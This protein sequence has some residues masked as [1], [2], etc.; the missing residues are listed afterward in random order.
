MNKQSPDNTTQATN[1]VNTSP[2]SGQQLGQ[3]TQTQTQSSQL[4]SNE[5]GSPVYSSGSS[6]GVKEGPPLDSNSHLKQAIDSDDYCEI[7]E[8]VGA[9]TAS[10][11][12]NISNR[13]DRPVHA[14]VS[15]RKKPKKEGKKCFFCNDM[16]CHERRFGAFCLREC[17]NYC[18]DSREVNVVSRQG[19]FEIYQRNYTVL[20]RWDLF[21]QYGN[22]VQRE[23]GM[24]HVP[25]CMMNG[26]Y[27]TSLNH[28]RDKF[29][30]H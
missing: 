9:P 17:K 29:D 10:T 28:F 21:R 23:K 30:L 3:M 20:V 22:E 11:R 16:P 25:E 2:H 4:V 15:V 14:D 5:G 13:M 6:T 12:T 1:V 19:L 18:A 24:L 8:L 7:L 27:I 26:S